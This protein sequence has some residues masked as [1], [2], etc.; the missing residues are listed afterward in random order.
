VRR[1]STVILAGRAL[2]REGI[3]SLLHNTPYKV[4]AAAAQPAELEH[5]RFPARRPL[6]AVVG[7]DEK[8]A[9]M[10]EI[11]ES[12]R[13]LRS[14]IP[15]AK[16]VIVAE[17]NEPV[18]LESVAVLAADAYIVNLGS[19]DILLKAL[20]LTLLDQQVFILGRHVAKTPDE[21]SE[22]HGAERGPRSG[23]GPGI[24]TAFPLS[25]RERQVLVCLA[26]GQSNKAIARLCQISEATVKVHL[27]AILRKTNARNRTQAA[28][29]AI[30]HGFRDTSSTNGSAVA[31][32]APNL[33]P[34][35]P[36][37]TVKTEIASSKS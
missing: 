24:D 8:D 7:M 26:H 2:L 22:I 36:V 13:L 12:I 15:D 30:E 37:V 11:A 1:R 18:D 6:L 35:E 4:I 32:D 5:V 21:E 34:A 17:T 20:E 23:N 33:S 10:E 19:R 29:W 31:S 25:N 14:F 27:K 16:V 9:S 3:A 28:I